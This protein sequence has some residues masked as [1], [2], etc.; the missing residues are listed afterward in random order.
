MPGIDA[1]SNGI[2]EL[3]MEAIRAKTFNFEE[4]TSWPALLFKSAYSALVRV[5]EKRS[6]SEVISADLPFHTPFTPPNQTTT[7]ANP[8]FSA[9][10]NATVA[11]TVS[12]SS[13]ESKAEHFTERFAHAFIE[14]S[15]LALE[16]QIGPHIPWLHPRAHFYLGMT[17]GLLVSFTDV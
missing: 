4:A 6:I 15:L 9:D 8:T 7:P 11:S 10:S 5:L 14:A 16:N 1:I 13:R 3:D 2:N 12:T 17:Y